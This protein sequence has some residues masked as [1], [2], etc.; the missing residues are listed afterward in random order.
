[1]S[2]ALAPRVPE[3][4]AGPPTIRY[5]PLPDWMTAPSV[6]PDG[7]QF[8]GEPATLVIDDYQ[9]NAGE[10]ALFRRTVASFGTPQGANAGSRLEVI[11]QPLFESLTI[12]HIT[13]IRDGD[14][15]DRTEETAFHSN[16]FETDAERRVKDG[17][18]SSSALIEDLRV[19]DSIDFAYSIIGHT[20]ALQ[21]AF[22]STFNYL[23]G[24]KPIG[25]LRIR[26]S[27]FPG[28]N[29]HYRTAADAPA[30]EEMT[31]GDLPILSWEFSDIPAVEP[32]DDRPSWHPI[33]PWIQTTTFDSWGDVA[34][35]IYEKW[36][37]C[38]PPNDDTPA[39]DARVAKILE[40]SVGDSSEA[41]RLAVTFIQ[42]SIHDHPSGAPMGI[43]PPT[44]PEQTLSRRMGDALDQAALLAEIF[45][46]LG[47]ESKLILIN[48][49]LRHRLSGILPSPLVFD[50]AI[51]ETR[52][53]GTVLWTD[54]IL[55]EQ[56]GTLRQ[57]SLPEYGSGLLID[58]GT[59]G[60]TSLRSGSTGEDRLEIVEHFFLAHRSL[61]PTVTSRILATGGE[62]DLLR[63]AVHSEGAARAASHRAGHYSALY[64]GASRKGE[65]QQQAEEPYGISSFALTDVF[66]ISHFGNPDESGETVLFPAKAHFIIAALPPAAKLGR[67][68]PLAIE[69]PKRI[70]QTIEIEANGISKLPVSP[71]EVKAPGFKF[72]LETDV[73]LTGAEVRYT[74]ESLVDHVKPV[75]L[76]AHNEALDQIQ[77]TL[78][79]VIPVPLA[80]G[81]AFQQKA[82]GSISPRAP[83]KSSARSGLAN[84]KTGLPAGLA[85]L[86]QLRDVDTEGEIGLG[87][88]EDDGIPVAIPTSS[89]QA[90]P[91]ENTEVSSGVNIDSDT[92]ANEQGSKME[93]WKNAESDGGPWKLGLLVALGTII[94]GGFVYHSSKPDSGKNK[95]DTSLVASY[96]TVSKDSRFVAASQAAAKD[97]LET[98]AQLLDDLAEDFPRNPD[99]ATLR[100]TFALRQDETEKALKLSREAVVTFPNHAGGNAILGKALLDS[101]QPSDAISYLEKSIL[102]DGSR[103]EPQRDLAGIYAKEGNAERAEILYK[104]VLKSEPNDEDTILALAKIFE[105]RGNDM[106]ARDAL[107]NAHRQFPENSGIA[108]ALAEDLQRDGDLQNAILTAERS[109]ASNNQNIEILNLLSN[110]HREAGNIDEAEIFSERANNMERSNSPE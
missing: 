99:L 32:E 98:A 85:P 20:P 80:R 9:A 78:S 92:L 62:A 30:P 74:Y 2:S 17:R 52:L 56:G 97:D 39:L 58:P 16:F 69:H 46:R 68:A 95:V 6:T 5:A 24:D 77:E 19:G 11:F 34:K 73:R 93:R 66:N 60:I 29:L 3:A 44:P 38:A 55:A 65:P 49:E 91:S 40:D 41:A 81:F 79:L 89:Q 88:I 63:S 47:S 13:L 102:L 71:M 72:T 61:E 54:P 42:D 26:V 48:R 104:R 4:L 67:I 27:G 110:L 108:I 103:P 10:Q 53:G 45:R 59:T 76:E 101:G 15:I 82:P 37:S 107:E 7:S 75:D 12:H 94:A 8:P 25:Y 70:H 86:T 84:R 96:K 87:S 22:Q 28:G 14:E 90:R 36:E 1:M 31:D 64:P 57:R 100:A 51:V 33:A 105:I 23:G 83:S 35:A 21:D 18:V 109:L 50:H 43:L 106:L